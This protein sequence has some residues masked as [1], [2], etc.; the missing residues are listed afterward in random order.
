M[1]LLHK[2]AGFRS[3]AFVAQQP[4]RTLID[5]NLNYQRV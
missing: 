3:R 4:N 1:D 2:S 5:A